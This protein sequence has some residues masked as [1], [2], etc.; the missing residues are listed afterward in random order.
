VNP[1][2]SFDPISAG[3]N[4]AGGLLG[5]QAAPALS[6]STA[7]TPVQ[8]GGLNTPAFPFPFGVGSPASVNNNSFTEKVI[9]GV[10]VALA[11]SGLVLVVKAVK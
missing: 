10:A 4:L 3:L 7:N 6:S 11:V 5:G 8:V 9:V 2:S 1:I